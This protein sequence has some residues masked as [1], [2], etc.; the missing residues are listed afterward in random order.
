MNDISQKNARYRHA[1]SIALSIIIGTLIIW[2]SLTP[3]EGPPPLGGSDKLHH[4]IAYFALAFPLGFQDRGGWARGLA[5]GSCFVLG[6]V[7]EVIQPYVGRTGEWQDA[8]AN[9][10]GILLGYV[11]SAWLTRRS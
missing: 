3:I 6:G 5:I 2:L 8:M 10:M 9:L 1:L 11:S 7:I 4:I